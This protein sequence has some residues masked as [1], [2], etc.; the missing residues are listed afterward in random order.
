MLSESAYGGGIELLCF[1]RY[2]RTNVHVY[3]VS[4]RNFPGNSDALN[5]HSATDVLTGPRFQKN[6]YVQC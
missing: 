2:R 1:S 4:R 3:R 5:P 6:I